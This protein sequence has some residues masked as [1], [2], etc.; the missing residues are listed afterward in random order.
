[1]ALQALLN[2]NVAVIFFLSSFFPRRYNPS[3]EVEI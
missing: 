2:L 1:M 3:T